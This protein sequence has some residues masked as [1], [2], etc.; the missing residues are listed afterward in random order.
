M[1]YSKEALIKEA[2]K[3][4]EVLDD[5]LNDC[6]EAISCACSERRVIR[7][8]LFLGCEKEVK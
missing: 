7:Y 3:K 8:L 6:L 2:I 5:T 4:L 1:D